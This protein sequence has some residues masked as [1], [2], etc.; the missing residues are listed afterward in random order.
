VVKRIVLV[1]VGAYLCVVGAIVHRQTAYAH[2][3]GWPWGLVLVLAATVAVVRAAVGFSRL[4]AAWLG[5]G[6]ALALTGLQFSPGGS[7][8]VASDWH[9][10]VF[11]AGCLGVIVV[12]ALRTPRVAR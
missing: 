2:G 3:V 8:L 12:A 4:G 6:W 5:L 1:V 9:G 7:Y 11:T 10:W